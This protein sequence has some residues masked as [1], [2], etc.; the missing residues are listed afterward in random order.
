MPNNTD[1]F[2]ACNGRRLF[3]SERD[4]FCVSLVAKEVREV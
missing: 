3:G 4:A 1:S 2:S